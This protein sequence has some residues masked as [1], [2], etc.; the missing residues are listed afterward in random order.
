MVGFCR[1]CGDQH[2]DRDDVW[3][4]IPQRGAQ[5]WLRHRLGAGVWLG[6]VVSRTTDLAPGAPWRFGDLDHDGSTPFL[7]FSCRSPVL[8]CRNSSC[9]SAPGTPPR[10]MA[11]DGSATVCAR[12]EPAQTFRDC[13]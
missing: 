8:R 13:G 2:F 3:N 12:T 11:P 5:F 7:A 6:L 1:S 10:E 9:F 4:S